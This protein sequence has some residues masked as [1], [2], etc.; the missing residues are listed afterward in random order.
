[1]YWF[2][3]VYECASVE[4]PPVRIIAIHQWND[5]LYTPVIYSQDSV[6]NIV[7]EL[8]YRKPNTLKQFPKS[9][10]SSNRNPTM[11]LQR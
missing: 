8:G 1:M 10:S 6:L 9:I 4:Q 3:N 5:I 2:V 7:A 11:C